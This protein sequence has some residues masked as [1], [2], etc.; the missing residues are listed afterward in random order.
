[1]IRSKVPASKVPRLNEQ[2]RYGQH[3]YPLLADYG[4]IVVRTEE[5]W[6]ADVADDGLANLVGQSGG[7]FV[8]NSRRNAY[9]L[10]NVPI[11]FRISAFIPSSVQVVRVER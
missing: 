5:N 2:L 10:N 1:M 7:H 4:L 3:L 6:S 8:L 9:A 11:E